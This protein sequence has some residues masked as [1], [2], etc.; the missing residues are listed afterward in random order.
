[1]EKVIMDKNQLKQLYDKDFPA[2]V[3]VNLE[4]IKSG[5]YSLVDWE[6][7]IEEIEDMAKSE[8]KTCLSHMA[9]IL[10]HMYK[11]DN[12]RSY[13]Q[14]GYE[15]GGRGWIKSV[16]NARNRIKILLKR[17]PSLQSKLLEHI[18]WAWDEAKVLIVDSLMDLGV[19]LDLDDL[20]EKCP[21]DFSQIMNRDLEKETDEEG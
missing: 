3:E 1:M 9:V 12:Y 6:N 20:P 18:D 15:K 5:D 10:E 13:T 14:A 8:L 4:L 16:V 7:L 2:W 21:Y 11:W 17:Y 19:R